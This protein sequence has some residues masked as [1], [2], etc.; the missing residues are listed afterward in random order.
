[1]NV[2]DLHNHYAASLHGAKLW[3]RPR[4]NAVTHVYAGGT[5]GATSP[6]SPATARL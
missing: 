5:Y 3:C 6:N 4:I 1:M 2:P